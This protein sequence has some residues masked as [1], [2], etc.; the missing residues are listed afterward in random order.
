MRSKTK[1]SS[2]NLLSVLLLFSSKLPVDPPKIKS[3]LLGIDEAYNAQ[4]F[5]YTID[6]E[7]SASSQ[8]LSDKLNNQIS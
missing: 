5:H 1:I 4:Q 7:I 8:L 3:L 2:T 6:F